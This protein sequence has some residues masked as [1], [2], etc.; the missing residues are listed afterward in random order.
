MRALMMFYLVGLGFVCQGCAPLWQSA[1]TSLV[2]PFIYRRIS[3]DYHECRRNRELADEAWGTF[4]SK[5]PTLEYSK[6]FECGFKEGFADYLFSGG[7]GAPP[8]VPPRCYWNF[9]YETP[10]GH[11]AAQNWFAGFRAGAESARESGYRKLVLIPASTVLPQAGTQTSPASS[12]SPSAASSTSPGSGTRTDEMLPPPKPVPSSE[13]PAI[14][15]PPT[16]EAQPPP[17]PMPSHL[18]EEALPERRQTSESPIPAPA[19]PYT[20]EATPR[21]PPV[22]FQRQ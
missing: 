6:D 18:S 2:Q 17:P 22:G 1:R 9:K 10:Q 19:F 13:N 15:M 20:A 3:T 4:F 16:S 12:P 8:P 21:S 14:E 11:Q 5:H 7:T